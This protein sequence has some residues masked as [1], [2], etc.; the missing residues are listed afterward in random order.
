MKT[1]Y[2][3]IQTAALLLSTDQLL[4]FLLEYKLVKN[5][6]ELA[7]DALDQQSVVLSKTFTGYVSPVPRFRGI[8]EA[9][10]EAT[11]AVEEARP[12]QRYARAQIAAISSDRELIMAQ[13]NL[14]AK[15]GLVPMP[16]VE[17]VL[18]G[19][20]P[21]DAAEDVVEFAR[22]VEKYPATK[23][24]LITT[25]AE[26]EM[27][28]ARA[29]EYLANARPPSFPVPKNHQL[30]AAVE[31]QSRVWTLLVKQHEQLWRYGAFIFGKQVDESVIPLGSRVRRGKKA[32]TEETT[33]PAVDPV[34]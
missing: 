27:M 21:I 23:A 26:L 12:V 24:T 3:S 29:K 32:A 22:L 30:E 16:E 33:T 9:L 1:A 8:L 14:F 13:L 17:R 28:T 15:A 25:P 10:G 4:T 19:H 34:S 7:A 20:G 31:W 2:Q 18:A 5:N 11:A 6:G